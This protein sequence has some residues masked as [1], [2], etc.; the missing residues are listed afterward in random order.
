MRPRSAWCRSGPTCSPAPW[1]ATCA[2]ATPT[3]PTPSCG[4]RW[5][6]PRPRDFVAA[7]PDG[8]ES[9]DR[10]GRHQRLAAA[11]GSGWRSPGRWSASRRSTCSTTRSPPWTSAPTPGCGRRCGRSPREATVLIVAQRVSTIVDA[12]QIIVL[13]DGRIVGQR[14][15]RRAAGDCPTYAEIVESQFAA[16]E[17]GVTHASTSGRR[18]GGHAT[19]PPAALRPRPGRGRGWPWPVRRH[20]VPAEKSLNFGPSGRAAAGPAGAGTAGWSR[21]SL[22]RAWSA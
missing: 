1:P 13:E 10:A 17:A 15:A 18:R 14:Q 21:W 19:A 3:P 20:G 4:R 7:M 22:P 9:R 2:T 5:R 8:L 16:E 11:S 12:D 6:S